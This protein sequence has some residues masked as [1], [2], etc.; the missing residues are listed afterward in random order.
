MEFTRNM[1]ACRFCFVVS[2]FVIGYTIP[3]T[4]A[5]LDEECLNLCK[6]FVE[7]VVEVKKQRPVGEISLP[8]SSLCGVTPSMTRGITFKAAEFCFNQFDHKETVSLRL[9]SHSVLQKAPEDKNLL[10]LLPT[11]TTVISVFSSQG[12]HCARMKANPYIIRCVI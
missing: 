8:K 10:R 6:Q 1:L 12:P 5:D 7:H 2:L 4:A 3:L 11:L 9:P